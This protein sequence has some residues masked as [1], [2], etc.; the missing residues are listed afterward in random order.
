MFSVTTIRRFLFGR[1]IRRT[2]AAFLSLALLLPYFACRCGDGS[3]IPFCMP[4]A[5]GRCAASGHSCCAQLSCTHC[6]D[7]SA[8]HSDSKGNG[9]L[10][11]PPCCQLVIHAQSTA[12]KSQTV[13]FDLT[14]SVDYVAAVA[15]P[16]LLP[17]VVPHWGRPF[18]VEQGPPPI[19]LVISQ[20][21]LTL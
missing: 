10:S 21:C 8:S 18:D 16:G 1:L 5:C 17:A 14:Q 20:Q 12:T 2:F 15:L 19:D 4:G 11:G 7:D 3:E 9:L 13:Q 6:C